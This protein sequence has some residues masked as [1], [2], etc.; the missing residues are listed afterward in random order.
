MSPTAVSADAVTACS[1]RS[2]RSANPRTVRASKMS[3]ANTIPAVMPAAASSVSN[4][5]ATLT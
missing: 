4:S 2:S 5:S 1:I 3:V